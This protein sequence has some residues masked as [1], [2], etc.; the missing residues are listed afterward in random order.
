MVDSKYSVQ[1]RSSSIVFQRSDRLRRWAKGGSRLEHY[2]QHGKAEQSTC[3]P[4]TMEPYTIVDHSRLSN[5]C[6]TAHMPPP[7]AI[8]PL[9][10]LPCDHRTPSR[11]TA[12]EARNPCTLLPLCKIPAVHVHGAHAVPCAS[13]HSWC[14]AL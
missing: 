14:A 1:S 3:S 9:M 5:A 13:H 7:L 10:Q 2:P 8:W 6:V 4:K 11:C 12:V